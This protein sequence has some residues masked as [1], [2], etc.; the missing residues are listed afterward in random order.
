M[1]TAK[2]LGAFLKSVGKDARTLLDDITVL[3]DKEEQLSKLPRVCVHAA[4]ASPVGERRFERKL[5]GG[6][7][8]GCWME[9][10]SYIDETVDAHWRSVVCAGVYV[11]HGAKIGEGAIIRRGTEIG[12]YS[13]IGNW[14]DI[15]P[16]E[17]ILPGRAVHGHTVQPRTRES[18]IRD[19]FRAAI[20]GLTI[21]ITDPKKK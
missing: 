10:G 9:T 7:R 15:G 21:E 13:I 4:I 1:L 19:I 2:D 8:N 5:E 16:G 11:G 6:K 20:S 14:N 17:R 12:A 3:V 18:D